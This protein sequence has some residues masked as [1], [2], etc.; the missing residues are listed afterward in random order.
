MYLNIILTMPKMSR[1]VHRAFRKSPILIASVKNK[2]SLDKNK[3]MRMSVKK[4]KKIGDPEA[5]LC[6]AVL[7]NNTLE[8][9][10][11]VRPGDS[12]YNY[13]TIH[14]IAQSKYSLEDE[15]LLS[16]LVLPLPIATVSQ[17]AL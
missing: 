16:S 17:D 2:N 15:E 11:N 5:L 7:I 6:K 13:S 14:T 9:L 10:R 8:C 1:P 12:S 4:L 3:M